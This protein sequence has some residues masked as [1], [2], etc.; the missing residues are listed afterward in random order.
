[1]LIAE[2]DPTV[3]PGLVPGMAFFHSKLDN[4]Q[5]VD[6]RAFARRSEPGVR[7]IDHASARGGGTSP[8]MTISIG[9]ASIP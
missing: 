7:R 6:G 1:L 8:A 9:G 4:K 5:D 3:M 2:R